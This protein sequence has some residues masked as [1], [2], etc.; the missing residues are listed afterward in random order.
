MQQNSSTGS[1]TA[2]D[3]AVL[4]GLIILLHAPF[5][6]Q[7]FHLDDVQYL[8]VALNV[9]HN[10]LFPMDMPSVFEGQH[11][12]LWGHTHPPLNAYLIAGL[13]FLHGGAPLEVFLHSVFLFF[14]ILLTISFYFLARRFAA[15]PLMASALLTT[16]PT[17]MISAHTLMADVPLVALWVC[18]TVLFL[19][20]I[21]EEKTD[22][23]YA[24]AIP[25]TAAC[26]YAYQGLALLP[27]LA[28]YALAR[29]R[30]N[31]ASIQVLGI[32]IV[33]MGAWQLSGY[34]HRGVSYASTMFEY[35]GVRGLWLGST[36]VKSTIVTL[37]YLGG[38]ILP[39]PFIFW[40]MGVRWK[41]VL[42]GASLAV[43]LI[44]ARQ[45]LPNYAVFAPYT[46]LEKAFFIACFA[47]GLTAFAWIVARASESWSLQGWAADE[48]FLCLWFVGMMVG[49]TLAFISGSA[50]YLLPAAPALL[51]LVMRFVKRAPVFYA[52]LLTVQIVL[53]FALSHSDYE[54]AGVGR[55]E[56]REF[57]SRYL[58]TNRPFLFSA[59]WGLRYYL[60]SSGGEIMAEDSTAS[61]GEYV[62]KSRLALGR[63]FN[64]DLDRSLQ[65]VEQRTYRI[66][67]P[68]RLL[69][70]HTHAGFWSDG[71]GV[72]PFWFS[73][74]ELDEFSIY[75]VP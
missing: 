31:G 12:T 51:L 44:V 56:S 52:S 20:G 64:N 33:L 19:R 66:R 13:V 54:F 72:L 14:P 47:A 49:C 9:A 60:H 30:L 27:L 10:P 70:P 62:V 37:T 59:E 2:R 7:A 29:R 38:T 45:W 23:V 1:R 63:S 26:F 39:F 50:R 69:D 32:P 18:A 43:A 65:L 22:F 36:K 35:I 4:V 15:D 75:R 53:G 40:K 67:S 58:T 55:R 21:D 61:P 74:Q 68:F 8:D 41:G 25:I 71:W 3:L 57:E 42:T 24:S 11:L 28:F 73:R 16:N 5:V 46:P 34:L 6:G 17:L 48:L